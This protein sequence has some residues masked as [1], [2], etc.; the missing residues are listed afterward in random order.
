MLEN[1][2]AS[3][4][5][6]AFDFF[7]SGFCGPVGPSGSCPNV[8]WCTR[9]NVIRFDFSNSN[10]GCIQNGFTW[11]TFNVAVVPHAAHAGNSATNSAR[12]LG[13]SLEREP[14]PLSSSTCS[15]CW[16]GGSGGIRFDSYCQISKQHAKPNKN[17]PS[18]SVNRVVLNILVCDPINS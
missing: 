18:R 7:Q 4:R 3:R 17:A 2:A 15:A 13:Q 12:I 5:T 9:H 1:L 14:N 8:K 11:C 6:F 10:S 16:S